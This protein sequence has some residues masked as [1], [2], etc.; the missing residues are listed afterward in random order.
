[1]DMSTYVKAIASSFDRNAGMA[2]PAMLL[3]RRAPT[4]LVEHLPAGVFARGSG[5]R[6]RGTMTPWFGIFD[7]DETTSPQDGLY[8]VYLFSADLQTISLSLNQG[9][10]LLGRDLGNR[11]ARDE[12]VRRAIAIRERLGKEAAGLNPVMNLGSRGW[13]QTAYQAGNVVCTSYDI[14]NL[15]SEQQMRDDL[16]RYLTLYQRAVEVRPDWALAGE[17]TK[18]EPGTAP[19]AGFKPRDAGDYIANIGAHTQHKSKR[20]EQIL[21]QYVAWTKAQGF[22]P[23]NAE[24][25]K[26][27]IL[28]RPEEEYLIE[29][30]V[31]YNGKA[32]IAVRAAIGQLLEYSHFLDVG[33]DP[34]PLTV[35]LFSEP[36]GD[37]FIEYLEVLE[38]PSVWLEGGVWRGSPTA[39]AAGLG[40]A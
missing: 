40:T 28:R 19:E 4:H 35:A 33:K 25:P 17:A 34:K 12:L 26:D 6:G 11:V 32:S 18:H 9:V 39:A 29:V 30:K 20:H 5:G 2:S 3:L 31:V 15:P 16:A 36:V 13:R 21:N 22:A 14:A 24:F 10:T 27:L 1:M 23:S 8:V 38:I 37:A 7:P